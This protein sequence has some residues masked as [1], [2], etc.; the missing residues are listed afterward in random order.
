MLVG[1]VGQCHARKPRRVLLQASEEIGMVEAIKA[2]L[3]Q[4]RALNPN[5]IHVPQ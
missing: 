4:Y 2:R 1:R 5:G 3:D